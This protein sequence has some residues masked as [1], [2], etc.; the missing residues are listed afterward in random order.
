MLIP[1]TSTLPDDKICKVGA[2]Y[3][4]ERTPYRQILYIRLFT[5]EEGDRPDCGKAHSCPGFSSKGFLFW[6]FILSLPFGFTGLVNDH[7]FRRI[8]M[9]RGEDVVFRSR[10]IREN[11]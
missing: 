5:C 9:V 1:G 7:Y 2:E 6:S 4:Y 8:G 10:R 3:W 11:L